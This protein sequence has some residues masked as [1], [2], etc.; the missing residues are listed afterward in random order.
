MSA[1]MDISDI[2]MQGFERY[3]LNLTAYKKPHDYIYYFT[4][5]DAAAIFF[6]RAEIHD[7]VALF[8][9]DTGEF[10]PCTVELFEE[11]MNAWFGG[12]DESHDIV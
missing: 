4:R 3:G 9:W 7:G 8:D 12:S 5:G 2:H 11:K 10:R 6:D 1:T